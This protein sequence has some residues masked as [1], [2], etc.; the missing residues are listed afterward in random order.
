MDFHNNNLGITI[1]NNYSDSFW[2]TTIGGLHLVAEAI[3][4]GQGRR[5][6]DNF[7]L[8]PTDGYLFRP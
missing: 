5:V 2:S 7:N 4:G 3:T 6:D 1:W 8:V